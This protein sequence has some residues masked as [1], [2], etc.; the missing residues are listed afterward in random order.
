MKDLKAA[1]NHYA[2][3]QVFALEPTMQEMFRSL[4]MHLLDHKMRQCIQNITKEVS[5]SLYDVVHMYASCV[6][7]R[8][9]V[10]HQN[11]AQ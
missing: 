5:T 2:M 7:Y 6:Q 11:I 1:T 8:A 3:H 4:A 9:L 10:E